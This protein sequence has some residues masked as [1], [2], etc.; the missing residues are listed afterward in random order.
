MVRGIGL[1]DHG[2]FIHPPAESELAVIIM[3]RRHVVPDGFVSD[4]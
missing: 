2:D 3:S 1:G 4:K